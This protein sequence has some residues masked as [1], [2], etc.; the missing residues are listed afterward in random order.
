MHSIFLLKGVNIFLGFVI[1]TTKI[2]NNART[3]SENITPRTRQC[4]KNDIIETIGFRRSNA[5]K[6]K[7]NTFKKRKI[8]VCFKIKVLYVY[9]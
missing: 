8:N 4:W 7:I 3:R 9:M 2:E 5:G 1:I 6:P